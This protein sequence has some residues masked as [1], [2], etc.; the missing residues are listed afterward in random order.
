MMFHDSYF[1]K[2]HNL[3]VMLYAEFAMC[4]LL[5]RRATVL[6]RLS[7]GGIRT[8]QTEETAWAQT[9]GSKRN[10]VALGPVT[11]MLSDETRKEGKIFERTRMTY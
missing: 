4:P 9:L 6:P 5:D 8:C 2:A 7:N 10:R 11:E 1:L 3:S